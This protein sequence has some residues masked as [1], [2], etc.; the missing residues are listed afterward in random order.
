LI[1]LRI[2][3]LPKVLPDLL[4]LPANAD[5]PD[6]KALKDREALK[7]HQEHLQNKRIF[8]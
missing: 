3:P 7:V 1:T 6:L 8:I 2:H 4:A 5:L